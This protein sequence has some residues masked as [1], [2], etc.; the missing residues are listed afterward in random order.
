MHGTF[1]AGTALRS[2]LL[3]EAQGAL[4]QRGATDGN[5]NDAVSLEKDAGKL[6]MAEAQYRTC[7]KN[8]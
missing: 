8:T 5:D 4:G 1:L 2:A 3:L 6:V 7:L